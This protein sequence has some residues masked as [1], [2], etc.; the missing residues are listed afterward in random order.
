MPS[1]PY[2]CISQLLPRTEIYLHYHLPGH[3]IPMHDNSLH[4][5]LQ[6]NRNLKATQMNIGLRVHLSYTDRFRHLPERNKLYQVKAFFT[7]L[8]VSV[9][10]EEYQ[11]YWMRDKLHRKRAQAVRTFNCTLGDA[12]SSGSHRPTM[13]TALLPVNKTLNFTNPAFCVAPF[14]FPELC[15]VMLRLIFVNAF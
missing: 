9:S 13:T 10:K 15:A 11:N 7:V 6:S 3:P 8:I 4:E 2:P 5:R 14:T 1:V 12:G